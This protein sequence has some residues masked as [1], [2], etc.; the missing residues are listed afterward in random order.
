MKDITRRDLI[1]AKASTLFANKGFQNTTIQEIAKGANISEASIYEQFKNKEDLLF[2]IPEI[3]FSNMLK[4]LDRH[5]LGVKGPEN[6]FRKFI[7]HYL[8]YIQ[9]REEFA[10]F[11]IFEIWSNPNYY[12]SG[13][14]K[15]LTEYYQI[16]HDIVCEGIK[17]DVFRDDFDISTFCSMVLGTMNHLLLS[18]IML[19]KPFQLL[20]KGDALET[21]FFEAV[22]KRDKKENMLWA[23]LNKKGTILQAA[24]DEFNEKGYSETTV[25]KIASRANLTVP[26]IYDYF[27]SK[28]DILMSIPELAVEN[29]LS[30]LKDDIVAT[31]SPENAF[32]LYLLNQ[33]ISFDNYPKYYKVLLKEIRSNPNFYQTKAYELFRMYSRELMKILE[34][35]VENGVFRED[36]DLH[37]VRDMFFGTFDQILLENVIIHKKHINTSSKIGSIYNLIIHAIKVQHKSVI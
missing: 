35:G 12:E 30:E 18:L 20:D 24:L 22:R 26:T 14:N 36:I 10:R 19:Q 21:L 4:S 13:K 37:R 23:D 15:S 25:A 9:E 3:T 31:E 17:E 34:S 28:E 11:F 29:F 5:L 33:A 2:T 6:Q 8:S 7:W 1:M 32:K 16:L 27:K